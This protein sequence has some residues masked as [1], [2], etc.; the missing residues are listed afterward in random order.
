MTSVIQQMTT[1]AKA[2]SPV[3]TFSQACQHDPEKLC[4]VNDS[5]RR[6]F[7]PMARLS[8]L[9][10]PKY[11]TQFLFVWNDKA[12][13]GTKFMPATDSNNSAICIGSASDTVDGH[14]PIR[15]EE[16][17]F[18]AWFTSLV[19]KAD[20][21]ACNLIRANEAPDEIPGPPPD[22]EGEPVPPGMTRLNFGAAASEADHPVLAALP[23][24]LPLPVGVALPAMPIPLLQGTIALEQQFPLFEI[25]CK[26]I[27]CIG[28]HNDGYPVSVK[29]PLFDPNSISKEPFVGV[30][31]APERAH[32]RIK[33]IAPTE[34]QFEDVQ[35]ALEEYSKAMWLVLAES[36]PATDSPLPSA[37]TGGRNDADHLKTIAD[38]LEK[39]MRRPTT[40]AEVELIDQASDT[41]VRFALAFARIQDT[42]DPDEP[43]RV[44]PAKATP[45]LTKLLH[46]QTVA[47]AQHLLCEALCNKTLEAPK[48]RDRMDGNVTFDTDIIDSAFAACIRNCN[49]V[50]SAI[51]CNPSA[52]KQKMGTVHF[53]TA[54][55][56]CATCKQC[57]NQGQKASRQEEA[58]E[59]AT[60]KDKKSAELCIGGHLSAPSDIQHMIANFRMVFGELIEDIE[61]SELWKQLAEFETVLQSKAG[62]D[63]VTHVGQ[64][65]QVGLHLMINTQEIVSPFF[66]L[67]N[68]PACR[69]AVTENDQQVDPCACATAINTGAHVTQTLHAAIS[70]GVIGGCEDVPICHHFFPQ[71]KLST[72]EKTN[73]ETNDKTNDKTNGDSKA[74]KDKSTKQSGGSSDKNDGKQKGFLEFAAGPKVRPPPCQIYIEGERF[75]LHHATKNLFCRFGEKCN[76]RHFNSCKDMPAEAQKEVTTFVKDNESIQFVKGQGPTGAN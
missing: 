30:H 24:F 28:E 72:D 67:G 38:S 29:G 25:W 27:C 10:S 6:T 75:C 55:K 18:V 61:H 52:V 35:A 12:M 57:I 43:C 14:L 44:V 66:Q 16:R 58:E 4:A 19:K 11:V 21:E 46:A 71:L 39:S 65:P 45:T 42:D 60:K 59:E 74:A 37:N 32:P 15:A 63:W 49:F 8:F 73:D 23:L 54:S 48:S 22:G 9:A 26:A 20:A 69:T 76:C 33:S 34:R 40:A 51:Q 50:A 68:I 53:A 3:K 1:R 47:K 62:Q 70:R 31:V 17:H 41:E 64:N 5:V 2:K 13:V 36:L 56:D 7:S